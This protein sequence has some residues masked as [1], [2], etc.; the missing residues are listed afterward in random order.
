VGDVRVGVIGFGVAVE[1]MGLWLPVRLG[2]PVALVC[3]KRLALVPQE[4]PRWRN[5]VFSALI[6]SPL[7]GIETFRVMCSGSI[8]ISISIGQAAAPR[9]YSVEGDCAA[10]PLA[11]QAAYSLSS[12]GVSLISACSH[13]R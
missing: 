4:L 3:G 12:L 1:G 11:A 6:G 5:A 9:M 10:I 7:R 2:M 13:S 8:L